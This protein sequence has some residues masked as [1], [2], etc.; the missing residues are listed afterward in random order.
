MKKLAEFLLRLSGWRVASGPPPEVIRC[1]LTAAPHTSNWDL[2]YARLGM[3]V[4]GAPVRFMIKHTM[5]RFPF[6]LVIAPLGGLAIDRRP[7]RDTGER[8]SY[9]DAAADLFR[10]HDHLAVMIAPEGSR[11]LRRQWKTGFYYIALKA[12]VPICLGYLDYKNKI[13]GVGPAIYP[14]GDI[15]ADLRRIMDFYRKIEGKYPTKFSLDERYDP[16]AG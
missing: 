1:V 16:Q 12:G 5:M 6:N 13:A 2:W 3:Y 11:S 15:D 4:L 9:I 14:S 7:R 8:P 10:R